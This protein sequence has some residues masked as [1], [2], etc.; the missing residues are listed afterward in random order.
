MEWMYNPAPSVFMINLCKTYWQL[1]LAQDVCQGLGNGLLFCPTIALVSIYFTTNR[2]LAISTVATGAG[3]G[4]VVFPLI[5]Q[6]LLPRIG[7]AWTMRVT[8]LI[9]FANSAIVIFTSR[10]ARFLSWQLFKSCHILLFTISMFSTLWAAYFAYY[11]VSFC[12]YIYIFS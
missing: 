9:I 3:T 4:G 2:S 8:G 12:G 1:F 11:H 7:S 10:Q 6:Q 5:A